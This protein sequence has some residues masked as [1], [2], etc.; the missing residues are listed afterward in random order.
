MLEW[1]STS[2]DLS[3][4]QQNFMTES[5]TQLIIQKV[6][7]PGD[8]ALDIGANHGLHTRHM[9]SSVGDS[10]HV[11]AFEPNPELENALSKILRKNRDYLH[12]IAAYNVSK[13]LEFFVPSDDGWGTLKEELLTGKA[14]QGKFEVPADRAEKYVCDEDEVALIKIDVEGSELETI[15]GLDSII[16]KSHPILIVEDFYE[17]KTVELLSLSLIHI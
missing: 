5:L 12:Q 2:R 13:R 8:V 10:G 17:F 9:V 1:I 11:H 7:K 3:D 15:Q 4:D 6:I 16:N 14:I